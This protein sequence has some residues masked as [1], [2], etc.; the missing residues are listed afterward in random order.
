MK[1]TVDQLVE[2]FMKVG[3]N[4][5]YFPLHKLTNDPKPTTCGSTSLEKIVEAVNTIKENT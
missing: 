2:A 4:L 3:L 1:I 5:Q